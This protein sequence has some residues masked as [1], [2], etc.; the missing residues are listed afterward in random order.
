MVELRGNFLLFVW[1]ELERRFEL[2]D[3][4]TA[5]LHWVALGRRLLAQKNLSR[6]G[7]VVSRGAPDE[8]LS[9]LS[10][11]DDMREMCL[12]LECLL[13]LLNYYYC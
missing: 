6:D 4:G 12:F 8:L 10:P 5:V 2:A 1:V 11:N 13:Q 3:M 9:Y 7:M